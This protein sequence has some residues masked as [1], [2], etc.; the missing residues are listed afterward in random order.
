MDAPPQKEEAAFDPKI[1]AAFVVQQTDPNSSTTAAEI[2]AAAPYKVMLCWPSRR[3]IE[4]ASFATYYEA[5]SEVRIL[6]AQGV[7]ATVE[8]PPW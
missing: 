6:R 4:H 1:E 3:R 8:S 5:L 7:P 2:N